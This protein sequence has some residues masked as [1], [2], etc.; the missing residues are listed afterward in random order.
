[1]VPSL[2]SLTTPS[3][4]L[5]YLHDHLKIFPKL[6]ALPSPINMANMIRQHTEFP[7]TARSTGKPEQQAVHC[8]TANFGPLPRD[9]ITNPM[10]IPVFDLYLTSRSLGAGFEPRLFHFWIQHFNLHL[11]E[12]G[13]WIRKSKRAL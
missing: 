13:P 6:N 5:L 12:P 4:S 10:L 8:S 3:P 11:H 2:F 1:M 7:P 9:N